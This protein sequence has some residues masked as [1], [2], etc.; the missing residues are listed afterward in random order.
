LNK[1][2][3]IVICC[4]IGIKSKFG[5]HK[6]FV[7]AE[8]SIAEYRISLPLSVDEYKIGQLYS[9]SKISLLETGGGEGVEYVTNEPFEGIIPALKDGITYKGQYT[10][11]IIHL[12]SK[13]PSFIRLLAPSGSLEIHEKSW[14]AYPTIVTEYSNPSYMKDNFH[15]VIMSH[16]DDGKTLL[17]NATNLPAE[18]L[19]KR[20][21]T[22]LD[23]VSYR[24]DTRD[25]DESEDPTK[26]KSVKTGLGPLQEGWSQTHEPLMKVY[27]SY[28]IVFK[29][30][31]LQEKVE[32]LIVKAISR[33]LARSNRR[34]FAWLDEWHGMGI[35]E[36]RQYEE[37]VKVELDVLRSTGEPRGMTEK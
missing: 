6:Q 16:H 27:K 11:K 20:V 33:L 5:V 1:I 23:I 10:H 21:I 18:Q 14:N 35:D 15:I 22:D 32:R 24:I 28:D 13:V 31:G 7:M 19:A 2:A 3:I 34:L 17:A 8:G 29:W 4:N 37:K 26:F 36:I 25:Y 30:W 12:Q 9:V